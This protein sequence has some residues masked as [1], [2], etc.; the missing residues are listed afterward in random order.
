MPHLSSS[1]SALPKDVT[2]GWELIYFDA[3]TRGEQIRLL[4][5]LANAEFKDTRLKYP[6]GLK[7]YKR[8]ALG[9][10]S[11]LMFNQCPAVRTPEGTWVS[12]TVACMQHAGRTLALAPPEAALDSRALTLTLGAEEFRNAI[13]YRLLLPSVVSKALQVRFWGLLCWLAPIVLWWN[14]AYKVAR[15]DLPEKLAYFEAQLPETRSGFF[16]GS[17]VCYADVAVFDAVRE[18]LAMPVVDS[19][20]IFKAFPKMASFLERMETIPQLSNYLSKRGFAFDVLLQQHAM[21]PKGKAGLDDG[22]GA[23]ANDGCARGAS[24]A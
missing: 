21:P 6:E 17:S 3:P 2:H 18:T 12:Q 1:F 14:G 7:A 15:T 9:D 11:P 13:F 16:C 5:K 22:E 8:E 20:R 4:F 10:A 19:G 23:A 24:L